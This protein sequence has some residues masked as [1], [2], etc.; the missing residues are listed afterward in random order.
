M[1]ATNHHCGEKN[2]YFIEWATPVAWWWAGKRVIGVGSD[3]SILLT[4]G[5]G[6]SKLFSLFTLGVCNSTSDWIVWIVGGIV[7]ILST[8]IYLFD[9]SFNFSFASFY[10]LR[11]SIHTYASKINPT[12]P[13]RRYISDNHRRQ[14]GTFS[15]MASS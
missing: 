14:T 7:S 1:N 3:F 11:L 2:A 9:F 15:A 4:E 12:T 8:A 10:L 6:S 5:S 13:M